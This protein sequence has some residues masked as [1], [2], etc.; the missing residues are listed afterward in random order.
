MKRNE[1]K[2]LEQQY[3]ETI[4]QQLVVS[5][6][7]L[8]AQKYSYDKTTADIYRKRLDK[9]NAEARRLHDELVNYQPTLTPCSVNGTG[10]CPYYV[11]DDKEEATDKCI[12]QCSVGRGVGAAATWPEEKELKNPVVTGDV[13]VMGGTAWVI[14]EIAYQDYDADRDEYTIEFIDFKGMYHYWKQKQDGGYLLRFVDLQ[15]M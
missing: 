7:L 10:E 12:D 1:K 3:L 15:K 11:D 8:Q 14:K 4:E 2:K 9:I 6:G 5:H 13:I